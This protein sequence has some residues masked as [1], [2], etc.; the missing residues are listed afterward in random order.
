MDTEQRIKALL[1]ATPDRL[2]AFDAAL[3]R[4]RPEPERP[5]LHLWRMGD[6][7]KETGLSR[8]TLWRAIRE[9]RIKTVEIRKDSHRIP[10]TELRRFV[11][12]KNI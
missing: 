3:A 10:E 6:A 8:C 12:G 7:A 9:G 11:E 4:K 2:A 1:S 5:S